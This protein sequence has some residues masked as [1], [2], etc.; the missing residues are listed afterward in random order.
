M[1]DNIL[2]R[3]LHVLGP[4]CGGVVRYVERIIETTGVYGFAHHVYR[5][6]LDG[7]E[8]VFWRPWRLISD[9]AASMKEH[10]ID[11]CHAH[12]YRAGLVARFAARNTGVPLVFN[13]HNELPSGI[14]YALQRWLYLQMERLTG[15]WVDRYVAVSRSL[16]EGF[17]CRAHV[18]RRRCTVAYL[19]IREGSRNVTA[20][21]KNRCL[22][23]FGFDPHRPVVICVA[24]LVPG[25]GIDLLL[26]AVQLL[27]PAYGCPVQVLI[28]GDG[29]ERERL[30]ARVKDMQVRVALAGW[31]D[32]IDDLLLLA[33]VF[34]LPSESEG[35]PVS[36]LE[37]VRAGV[38]VVA[39]AAGG[40]PEIIEDGRSGL[41]INDRRPSHLAEAIN[42]ILSDPQAAACMT[43]EAQ[44]ILT[45]RF[46]GAQM[47]ETFKEIYT[48]VSLHGKTP[49]NEASFSNTGG[50]IGRRADEG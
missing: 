19:G 15:C 35:M 28:A 31:R 49:T 14:G 5:M 11:I 29:P 16:G 8:L 4:A 41:L 42:A 43:K 50:R 40:I 46:T 39:T 10:R 7:T 9:L 20:D 44:Q 23:K 24:R 13:L 3:I 17:C 22:Q 6:A 38:P 2:M 33:D 32:D 30:A 18:D 48:S 34:V 37:A 27:W 1:G 12:G 21:V 36:V 26:D 47:G 45:S 25:K